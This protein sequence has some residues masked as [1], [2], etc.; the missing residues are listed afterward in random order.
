MWGSPQFLKEYYY[1]LCLELLD[2]RGIKIEK[3]VCYGIG[4][5]EDKIALYQVAVLLGLM[6][7]FQVL[8]CG[9]D[10]VVAIVYY[11]YINI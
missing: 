11:R 2:E 1:F 8:V 7:E 9:R 6:Q 5:M 3:I 10:Y 4:K